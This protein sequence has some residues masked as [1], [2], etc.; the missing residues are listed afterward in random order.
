MTSAGNG[1][2]RLLLRIAVGC[3][4]G[5]TLLVAARFLG[6]LE[7]GPP[8]PP[9]PVA[10]HDWD[11]LIAEGHRV[12][13]I[14]ARVVI[15]EF[16]DF[17]CPFCRRYALE[18][19][20]A[21]R[22]AYPDDVAVI[23]RHYPL[24]YHRFAIPSAVAADCAAR[25]GRFSPMHD[26]LYQLQDSLGLLAWDDIA[27]RSGVPDLLAWEACRADPAVRT[28]VAAE[29]ELATRLGATGTPTIVINGMRYAQPPGQAELLRVVQKVLGE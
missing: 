22:E 17:E 4:A 29:G 12:G 20:P 25:Q 15:V 10:V 5:M 6:V 11:G 9:P 18:T 21:V 2:S 23:Y 26:L 27:R 13:P 28:A 7:A 8:P 14:D 1:E 16:A 24:P 19:I 3:A